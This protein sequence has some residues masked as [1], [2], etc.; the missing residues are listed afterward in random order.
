MCSTLETQRLPVADLGLDAVDVPALAI[1]LFLRPLSR[2]LL[3]CSLW[4][5][6]CYTVSAAPCLKDTVARPIQ[7]GMEATS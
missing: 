7:G 5:F 4:S 1:F 2:G 3:S 6:G